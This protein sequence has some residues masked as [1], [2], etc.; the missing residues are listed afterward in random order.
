YHASVR[1]MFPTKTST[2]SMCFT[3]KGIVTSRVVRVSLLKALY[4]REYSE[5]VAGF[6]PGRFPRASQP[7]NDCVV[8]AP[9]VTRT[10]GTRFRKPLLYPPE[11]RGHIRL[12]ATLFSFVAIGDL[13]GALCSAGHPTRSDPRAIPHGGVSGCVAGVARPS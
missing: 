3:W 1:A 6:R 2:W 10:P 5:M 13:V 12:A 8:S 11:L 7:E 4:A 9:G